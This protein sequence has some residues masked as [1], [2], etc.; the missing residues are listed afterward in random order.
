MDHSHFKDASQIIP[1]LKEFDPEYWGLPG[2]AV[3]A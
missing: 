2:F 1:S 3:T